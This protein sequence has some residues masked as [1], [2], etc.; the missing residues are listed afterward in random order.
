M[1]KNTKVATLFI[2][3]FMSGPGPNGVAVASVRPQAILQD[4]PVA[5]AVSDPSV[6]P[7]VERL[8]ATELERQQALVDVDMA[9]VGALTADDFELIPPPGTPLSREEY[10]GAVAVGAID[11]SV[12]EP[13]SEMTVRLYGQAAAMRYLA[14]IDVVVAGLGHFD[15]VAYV[16]CIYERRNGRWQVVWEQATAVGGFPP[17]IG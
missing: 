14:H 8:R 11:Y 6:S 4:A 5:R 13:V 7:E 16:T 17:P 1:K 10:L 3:L 9:T 15:T 2:L 12:F